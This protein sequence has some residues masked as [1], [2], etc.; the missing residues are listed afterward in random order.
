MDRNG[1]DQ[2]MVIESGSDT[3]KKRIYLGKDLHVA[4]IVLDDESKNVFV[5]AKHSSQVI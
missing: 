5:T 4:H 2:L 3:I 1:I